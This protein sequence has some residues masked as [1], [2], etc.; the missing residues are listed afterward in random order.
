[1]FPP[2]FFNI[3]KEPLLVQKQTLHLQKA[4]DLSYNLAPQKWAWHYQEGATLS[5]RKKHRC[6]WGKKKL[7]YG[8]SSSRP[9]DNSPPFSFRVQITL[10]FSYSDPEGQ[11]R[12]TIMRA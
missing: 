11:G 7:F 6:A 12:G 4:L 3:V 8:K 9:H 1:M 10:D 2:V 5:R